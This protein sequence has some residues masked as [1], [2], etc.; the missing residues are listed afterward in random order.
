GEPKRLSPSHQDW[1]VI[2]QAATATEKPRTPEV[3]T[4]YLKEEFP[5]K[6]AP[7]LRAAAVIR[8]RRSATDFDRQTA[9]PKSQLLALLERTLPRNRSAPFD[10]DFGGPAVHLLVFIHRVSGLAPG[11]YSLVRDERDLGEL[12]QQFH[13][14]FLWEKVEGTSRSL[15]FYLLQ[16]GDVRR[17]GVLTG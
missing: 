14:D 13:P 7:S 9:W 8:K 6:E 12:R 2:D 17:A 3:P 16:G 4:R 15:G 5:E 1:A 11:L 10:L